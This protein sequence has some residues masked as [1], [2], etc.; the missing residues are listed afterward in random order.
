MVEDSAIP[1]M[2]AGHLGF[3]ACGVST[4]AIWGFREKA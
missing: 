4:I 3:A 2:L 1:V